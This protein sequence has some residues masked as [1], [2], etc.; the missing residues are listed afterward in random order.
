VVLRF[1]ERVCPKCRIKFEA[2][3]RPD[4]PRIVYCE[5]CYLKEIV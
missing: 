1:Y 2:V 5:P 4:D 3:Y